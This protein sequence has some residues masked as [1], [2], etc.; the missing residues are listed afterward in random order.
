MHRLTLLLALALVACPEKTPVEASATAQVDPL[1]AQMPLDTDVRM[2]TLDNGMRYF[3]ENNN[4]PE[5]RAVFRLVIQAGSIL[6]DEDQLGLAHFVEHMAFNGTTHFEGNE[7][8][9]YLESV[10]TRFGAHLNAHT[11]FDETVYKLVVPTDDAEIFDKAFVIME[12]WAHGLKFDPEEVEKERGVVLEEWRRG[13]GAGRRSWEVTMPATYPGSPYPDRLPIGTEESLKTFEHEALV[14]F[15]NDWYRPD[16]MS[17]IVV[18]DVEPDA[19]EALIKERFGAIDP[20]ERPRERVRPE[21]S[22]DAAPTT[23]V[24]TDPE[25]TRTSISLQSAMDWELGNAYRDYREGFIESLAMGALNERLGDLAQDPEA[26]F[27]GIGLGKS[28][29]SPTEGAWTYS[30]SPYEG[31][32]DATYAVMLTELKRLKEHGITEA[33]LA[34]GKANQMRGMQTYFEERETTASRTHAEEIIRHVTTGEPM[35]GIAKEWEMAQEYLPTITKAEVDAFAKTMM[36]MAN[37]SLIL[38]APEKEG[39]A[40][41]TEQ[42]LAEIA[43]EVATSE[44]IAPEETVIDTPLVAEPPAPGTITAERQEEKLGFTVWTLSNGAEVWFKST[45]FEAEEVLLAGRSEG[46]NNHLSNDDYIAAGSASGIRAGSGL[47]DLDARD[48][49]KRLAGHTASASTW[50]SGAE[51]GVRGS[52]HPDDLDLMFQQ[53]WLNFAAPRFDADVLERDQKRRIEQIRN[54]DLNPSTA[55]WDA[56]RT[57]EWQDF[58]RFRPWTE[59]QVAL[60]DLTASKAHYADRFSDASDFRFTI[61]GSVDAETIKPLVTQWL[62]ALPTVERETKDARVELGNKRPDGVFDETI[63]SGADPKGHVRMMFHG[64]FESTFLTRNRLQAFSAVLSVRLR[65]VLR[66]EKGGVYGVSASANST[67][68]PKTEYTVTVDF[69]CDPERI[70]ELEAATMKVLEELAEAPVDAHYIDDH[71]AKSRRSRELALKTNGFWLGIADGTVTTMKFTGEELDDV[72]DYDTRLD[73]LSP[74]VV[75]TMAAELLDFDRQI[76]MRQLPIEDG[77]AAGE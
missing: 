44:V 19:V 32:I 5:Q 60:M 27:K 58:E 35:P 73:Q 8:I 40:I 47:G 3:I 50:I 62:A 39:L 11:S 63:R 49:Q 10:G 70:P 34:R 12:D 18:G 6:E 41:P 51:E 75:H 52:A 38:R 1:D 31:Q 23:V 16:L 36:P 13:L 2:G 72:L 48:L 69:V 29:L 55:F 57:L 30:A 14:R 65:E 43:S 22:D 37:R 71:V 54:R 15:Y 7:L 4:Q 20:S 24:F 9:A 77:E 33:E 59:A 68:W 21:I 46:G 25:L 28:R 74:E 56:W 66:E 17:L 26:P 67:V 64:P 53:L 76:T 45:D 61:V 42:T